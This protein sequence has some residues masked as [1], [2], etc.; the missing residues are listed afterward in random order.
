[1][2]KEEFMKNKIYF[3]KTKP[4]A[5]IPSKRKEDAGYDIYPCFEDNE[6][7]IPIGGIKIIPTG[8]ASAFS[9][10][11]V[12]IVKERG[13]TGSKCMSVRMGVID[14]GYRNEIL[15]GINNTGCNPIIIAKDIEKTK[16]KI[17][18]IL[19]DNI[20]YYP[21]DKAIAQL[22]L[23]PIPK[24]KVEEIPYEDLLKIKSERGLGNFGSSGK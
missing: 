6:I 13:S 22:L 5:I 3:A 19:K 10:D 14:S 12:L 1:V 8:I 2:L 16:N 21:Y 11:Y 7:I 17:S 4:D 20:I 18:D 9:S 23:L 15:I 24:V